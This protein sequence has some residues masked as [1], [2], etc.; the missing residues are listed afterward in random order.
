MTE[1]DKNATP[2]PAVR[3][4]GDLG[5]LRVILANPLLMTVEAEKIARRQR[6]GRH[7]LSPAA[8][9]ESAA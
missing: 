8:G 9:R 5:L 4:D 7:D 1:P 3:H 6:E 2:P